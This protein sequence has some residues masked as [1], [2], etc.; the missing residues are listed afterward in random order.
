MYLY[1]ESARARAC[2]NIPNRREKVFRRPTEQDDK[3]TI[4]PRY[5]HMYRRCRGRGYTV[6]VCAADAEGIQI[7]PIKT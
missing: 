7:S 2:I 1:V 5:S 6:L 4:I 3:L